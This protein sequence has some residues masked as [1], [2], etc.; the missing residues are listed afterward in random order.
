MSKH[1]SEKFIKDHPGKTCVVWKKLYKTACGTYETPYQKTPVES[2]E[3]KAPRPCKTYKNRKKKTAIIKGGAIHVYKYNFSHWSNHAS[4][5]RGQ[6]VMVRC[7]AKM[8]DFIGASWNEA[9]FTKI[10]FP[11]GFPSKTGSK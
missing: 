9:C 6:I 4:N 7:T 1:Y 5:I 8:E 2:R 3:F 11:K 10:K